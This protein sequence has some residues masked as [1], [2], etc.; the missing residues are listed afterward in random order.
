MTFFSDKEK[1]QLLLD[2]ELDKFQVNSIKKIKYDWFN[3]KSVCWAARGSYDKM[4]INFQ[5]LIT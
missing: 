1:F 2:G 3:R 5:S 4:W